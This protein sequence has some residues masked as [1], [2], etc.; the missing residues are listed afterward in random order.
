MPRVPLSSGPELLTA[1][2]TDPSRESLPCA[3]TFAALD[4]SMGVAP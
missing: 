3:P 2:I 1:D 4:F